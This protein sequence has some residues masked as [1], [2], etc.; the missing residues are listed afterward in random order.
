M[1]REEEERQRIERE[2]AERRAELERKRQEAE[3]EAKRRRRE[4]YQRKLAAVM[5]A[6]NQ[7]DRVSLG[8]L[9]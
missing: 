3:E 1:K 2:A 6:T 7:K 8:N 4:D 5:E 9:L